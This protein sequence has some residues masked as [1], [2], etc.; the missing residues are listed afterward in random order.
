[1][2]RSQ[3]ATDRG[4]GSHFFLVKGSTAAGYAD[5]F[6]FVTAGIMALSFSL[7]KVSICRV[8]R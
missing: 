3:V 8:R 1:M 5:E 7:H 4:G 2:S 6:N